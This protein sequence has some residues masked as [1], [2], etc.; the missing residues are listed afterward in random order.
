MPTAV[1]YVMNVDGITTDPA[2]T[3]FESYS[4][5]ATA[6]IGS[7]SSGSGTGK[8]TFNP[9]SITRKVDKASPLLF[10]AC[11][12]G[13]HFKKV[14]LQMRPAAPKGT[15]QTDFLI[16]ALQDVLISNV[17]EAGNVHGGAVP[18]EEIGFSFR[19]FQMTV[20]GISFG[21][22]LELGKII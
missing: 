1:E 4:F 12:S 11:V 14:I 2:G 9:F 15:T 20:D 7:Q 8:I 18:L 10:K 6:N 13:Q 21:Y 3:P 22:D 16:V 19:A 17:S 5:S